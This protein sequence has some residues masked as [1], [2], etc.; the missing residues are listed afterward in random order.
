M[1][2]KPST[3]SCLPSTGRPPRQVHSVNAI[4]AIRKRV[5]ASSTGDV[6]ISMGLVATNAVPQRN[7][8]TATETIASVLHPMQT[9]GATTATTGREAVAA[10]ADPM[11][12][13][14]QGRQGLAD[15]T[16]R[17]RAIAQGRTPTTTATS[18]RRGDLR[19]TVLAVTRPYLDRGAP[20]DPDWEYATVRLRLETARYVLAEDYVRALEGRELLRREVD[21][22]LEGVAALA[23]PSLPIPAPPIGAAMVDVG[24]RREPVRNLMLRLTQL[25][26]ITGHPAVSLPCGRTKDGLPVGLQLVGHY[27]GEAALLRLAAALHPGWRAPGI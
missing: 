14:R 20:Q 16:Q 3:A 15:T 8:A 9:R 7:A 17:A 4:A 12:Q 27:R 21:R 5:K 10:A 6:C 26:N 11:D 25:F 19:V 24:S 23:L 1:P 18:L 13:P 2:L 22:A